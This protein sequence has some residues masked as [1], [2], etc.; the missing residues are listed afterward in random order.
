MAELL[1]RAGRPAVAI[2]GATAVLLAGAGC[3][4][5]TGQVT[6]SPTGVVA[7][8]FVR[9]GGPLGP[10]GQQPKELRLPGVVEFTAAG[11]RPVRVKVGKNGAFSVRLPP[12]TYSVSWR[13]PQIEQADGN[14]PGRELP[15]S[16]PLSVKVIRG[17]TSTVTV[18]C[19]VP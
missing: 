10:N 17:N 15:C 19:I 3:V 12:G 13:T 6:V 7:G 1:T 14:G 9:E 18:A 4:A 5:E 8:T 11:Q 16:A 2:V